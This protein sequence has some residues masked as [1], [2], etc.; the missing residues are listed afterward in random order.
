MATGAESGFADADHPAEGRT[1]TNLVLVRHAETI[2]HAENRYAGSSDIPLTPRG[3]EQAE[4]LAH[5]AMKADLTALWV[6]SMSRAQ[7]TAAATARSTGLEP[8]VDARLGEIHFGQGE[9]RTIA[10]ME[11][12]FPEVVAAYRADPVAH[13]L[14]GG[15]DP[16]EGVERALEC[17]R[18]IDARAQGRVLVV[19]H[20]TLIRLLLCRLIGLPLSEYRRAFPFVRSAAISEI[21][22]GGD[23]ASLLEFN[24]P[25]GARA[26]GA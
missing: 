21:H 3:Y 8:R 4:V 1:M 15:E 13:H 7:E 2:W 25:I 11:E 6:S 10:E 19:M 26:A 24:T 9:A 14:P 20:S 17:L 23:H 12:L 18:E 22:F 16:R 5:W